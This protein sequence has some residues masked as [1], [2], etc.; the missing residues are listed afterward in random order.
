MTP[1][2]FDSSSYFSQ[3][4]VSS[5]ATVTTSGCW[6]IM[7]EE[8]WWS[9]P[10]LNWR[11]WELQ[12]VLPGYRKKNKTVNQWVPP[13]GN[14]SGFFLFNSSIAAS[15]RRVTELNSTQLYFSQNCCREKQC[16]CFHPPGTHTRQVGFV[17]SCFPCIALGQNNI[18][19]PIYDVFLPPLTIRNSGKTTNRDFNHWLKA[20]HENN[21][22]RIN[23][24]KLSRQTPRIILLF[25]RVF[26]CIRTLPS[27]ASVCSAL[28]SKR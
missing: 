24:A 20:A 17:R 16:P 23:S 13:K 6:R 1:W 27:V 18:F 25:P 15:D 19:P 28:L 9:S 11:T 2:A 8:L 10:K 26:V 14:P 5:R 4:I 7:A 21:T 3:F 22:I 12:E